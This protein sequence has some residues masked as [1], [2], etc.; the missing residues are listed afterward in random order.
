MN[1]HIFASFIEL[2]EIINL[3]LLE[4]YYFSYMHLNI[5]Y[6]VMVKR[7]VIEDSKVKETI[8]KGNVVNATF[9]LNFIFYICT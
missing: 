9:G 1:F 2:H 6:L 8:P 7:E 4:R 3:I 5:I